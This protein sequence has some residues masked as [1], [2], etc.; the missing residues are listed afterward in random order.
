[1][2]LSICIKAYPPK[3]FGLRTHWPPGGP[4]R[5]TRA[6]RCT[7]FLEFACYRR[8]GHGVDIMSAD[9]LPRM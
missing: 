9:Y 6:F 8:G 1:M 4:P 2:I 3:K 5:K 7:D